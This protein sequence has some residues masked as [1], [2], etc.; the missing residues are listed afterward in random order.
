MTRPQEIEAD[1]FV[2]V[3]VYEPPPRFEPAH[4]KWL[5]LGQRILMAV[6][7]ETRYSV[8]RL[9]GQDR[10]VDVVR[11]RDMAVWL[12]SELSGDSLAGI[13][14]S[15]GYRGHS[16]I[17]TAIRRAEKRRETDIEFRETTERL[18]RR[19]EG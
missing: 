4:A 11:A 14:R 3:H 2:T 19:L 6:S 10:C 8:P 13:G 5:P 17:R 9:I 1:G 7:R 15:I 16:T 18:R 12:F